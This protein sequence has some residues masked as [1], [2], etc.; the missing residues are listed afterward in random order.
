[1][2]RAWTKESNCQVTSIPSLEELKQIRVEVVPEKIVLDKDALEIQD[3]VVITFLSVEKE[4][5]WIDDA[6][7]RYNNINIT[8]RMRLW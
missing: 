3:L 8:R 5:P 6:V 2:R 4:R 7:F 1:M